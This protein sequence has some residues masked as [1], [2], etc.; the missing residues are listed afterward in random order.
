MT[1]KDILVIVATLFGIFVISY[2]FYTIRQ[3]LEV[4]N[5]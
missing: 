4:L 1:K 3:V 2:T 5:A